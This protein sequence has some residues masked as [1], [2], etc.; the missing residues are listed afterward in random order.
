MSVN[1]ETGPHDTQEN[2]TDDEKIPSMIT[3]NDS[4]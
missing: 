1:T 3:V 4:Y 2:E